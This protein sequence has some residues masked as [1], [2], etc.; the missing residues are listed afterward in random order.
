[1]KSF[2]FIQLIFLFLFS[3]SVLSNQFEILSGDRSIHVNMMPNDKLEA[4]MSYSPKNE[5]YFIKNTSTIAQVKNNTFEWNVAAKVSYLK[6]KGSMKHQ[7]TI[8]NKTKQIRTWQLFSLDNFSNNERN[9]W[10]GAE[11]EARQCGPSR[12]KSLFRDCKSKIEFVQK[13]FVGLEPHKEIMIELIVHFIDQWDG[14]LAYLE[15]DDELV[16]TKSHKW[17]H[18]IFS[19]KCILNGI[20]VCDNAYPDLMGQ[21]VKFVKKH[22]K[23]S[24]TIRFGSSLEKDNCKATWGINNIMLYLR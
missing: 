22:N 7:S 24:V 5:F 11:T 6:I 13:R 21:N 19:Q 4:V 15:I 8:G 3:S 20:N 9:G 2:L 23:K 1:M 14:E 18:T 10:Q 16:W 17:C 12:D